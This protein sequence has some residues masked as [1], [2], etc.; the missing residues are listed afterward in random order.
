MNRR[1]VPAVSV[2]IR[3]SSSGYLT[4]ELPALA[5]DKSR[6][7]YLRMRISELFFGSPAISFTQGDLVN[8]SMA[9]K[10]CWGLRRSSLIKG[11]SIGFWC[12]I[13]CE[14]SDGCRYVCAIVYLTF[15][16]LALTFAY[17]ALCVF[18][19]QRFKFL[20]N[21]LQRFLAQL[22][23]WMFGNDSCHVRNRRRLE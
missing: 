20:Q 14:V 8:N 7:T 23:V 10:D 18:V 3:I 15:R 21:I 16:I 11:D 19:G 22:L 12:R 6:S 1:A 17:K 4:N 5:G 13:V 2:A 9:D